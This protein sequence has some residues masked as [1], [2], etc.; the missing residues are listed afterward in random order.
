MSAVVSFLAPVFVHRRA[1]DRAVMEWLKTP[2]P[3]TKTA[4]EAERRENQRIALRTQALGSVV[5]FI[6][7]NGVWWCVST[8][9]RYTKDPQ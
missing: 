9:A 5:L 6:G 8:L 1:F 2:T 7:F 4:L 3:A